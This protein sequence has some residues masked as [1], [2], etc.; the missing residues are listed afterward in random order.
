[1]TEKPSAAGTTIR[2]ATRL[3]IG[4]TPIP[5]TIIIARPGHEG[6]S[7]LH[8]REAEDQLQVLRDEVEEADE[9]DD[10]QQVDQHR[11][12]E[13]PPAEQRHVEHGRLEPV[14]AAHEQHAEHEARGDQCERQRGS[15]VPWTAISLIA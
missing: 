7:R 8:R 2:G 4:T 12:G 1:M 3:A 15:R 6:E 5:A 11:A 9:P 13:A 14:L 10:A